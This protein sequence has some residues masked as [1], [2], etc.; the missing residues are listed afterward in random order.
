MLDPYVAVLRCRHNGERIQDHLEDSVSVRAEVV[1]AAKVPVAKAER[2]AELVDERTRA[3]GVWPEDDGAVERVD[4]VGAGGEHR[5]L[6]RKTRD[7]GADIDM[8]SPDWSATVGIELRR[9]HSPNVERHGILVVAGAHMP[10][11]RKS[12]R[13]N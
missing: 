1:V 5:A 8:L 3:D 4:R 9:R 11:D 7:V 13:L 6:S 12:N 2:V 10:R